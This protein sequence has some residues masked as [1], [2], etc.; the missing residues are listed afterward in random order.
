MKPK[1]NDP[2]GDRPVGYIESFTAEG[3]IFH[4][5]KAVL[6]GISGEDNPSQDFISELKAL[7]EKYGANVQASLYERGHLELQIWAGGECVKTV[8][9]WMFYSNDL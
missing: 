8:D 1:V 4:G 2:S 5:G 6:K 7:L 3:R 9:G